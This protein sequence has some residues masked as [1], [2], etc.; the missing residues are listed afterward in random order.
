MPLILTINA[1][2]TS[3]EFKCFEMIGE[4]CLASGKFSDINNSNPELTYERHD[5]DS[6]KLEVPQI[7]YDN[8]FSF[9]SATLLDKEHGII[10]DMSAITA[11][12]HCV[13]HGGTHFTES[14]LIT[15]LT[16]GLME[17]NNH[18][19][20]L[21]NPFNL[22]G[23]R[24]CRKIMPD[25][26]QVAV[27]DTAFHQSIPDYA[28]V[29]PIP[30][31]FYIE[32]GIRRYGFHGI[33]HRYVSHRAAD[34][35]GRPLSNLKLISCHLGNSCSI[36][37][38]DGGCSVDTSM[39]FTPLEGLMMSTCSGN[40]DPSI[41]F[42]LAR[43]HGM[44]IDDIEA[45]LTENSGLRG[46]SGLELDFR[47][48]L[49]T[50]SIDDARVM[51]A[52]KMFCYRV[53]QYIGKYVASLGGL[54]ALIFTGEIGGNMARIRS[55][56]CEK[57]GFL[58]IEVDPN[59]NSNRVCEKE[60]SRDGATVQTFLIPTNVELMIA[61]ETLDLV[62]KPPERID[63]V[64]QFSRLME[65]VEKRDACPAEFSQL[66]EQPNQKG[67]SKLRNQNLQSEQTR[68][69]GRQPV[70]SLELEGTMDIEPPF[71]PSAWLSIYNE[72]P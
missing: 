12:G 37:A 2:N 63:R 14:Q 3:L 70:E 33:S 46:I 55:K 71:A 29:Y 62:Q 5:G 64:T 21:H 61:R 9:V 23:V 72:K 10:D 35:V 22:K 1:D 54:D 26:P 69:Y 65:I 51:L 52:L 16:E 20:P 47:E 36:T 31:E 68:I 24:L 40:I 44:S 43:E 11:V 48:F 67:N 13:I 30:Y 34:L 28:L 50:T 56:V 4:V 8:V 57:L 7:T 38:I 66:L 39:G 18:L 17:Q 19:A 45:F 41:I 59:K 25:T 42:H 58:G 53:S 32:H 27:F 15:P 49:N 6:Y 60:I